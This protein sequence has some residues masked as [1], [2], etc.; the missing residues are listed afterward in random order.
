VK[1]LP[2]DIDEECFQKEFQVFGP[3]SSIRLPR[4]GHTNQLKG[5]GYVVFK[6]PESAEIAVKKSKG[7]GGQ[8]NNGSGSSVGVVINNRT[9]IIDFE[10]GAPKMSFERQVNLVKKTKK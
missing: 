2:Y 6:R 7:L 5:F 3:I 8:G 9:L 10:T 4:W 1:N